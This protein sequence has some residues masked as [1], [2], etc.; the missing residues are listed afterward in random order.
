MYLSRSICAGSSKTRLAAVSSSPKFL[1]PFVYTTYFSSDIAQNEL[2]EA[3]PD[4][5]KKHLLMTGL[6]GSGYS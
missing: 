2:H 4:A 1:A 6:G 3:L 5:K